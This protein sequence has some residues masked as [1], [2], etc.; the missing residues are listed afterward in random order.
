MPGLDVE[1]LQAW[2]KQSCAVQG[3]PVHVTDPAVVSR[4]GVLLGASGRPGG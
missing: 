4:L 3:V 2:V 1:A